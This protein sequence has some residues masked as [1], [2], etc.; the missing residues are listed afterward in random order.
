MS[1]WNPLKPVYDLIQAILT[2]ADAVDGLTAELNTLRK[3]EKVVGAL[4]QPTDDVQEAL[5]HQQ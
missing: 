4:K 1:H 3:L 5:K 2:L